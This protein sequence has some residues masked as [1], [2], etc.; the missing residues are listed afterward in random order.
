[1]SEPGAAMADEPL[2][3]IRDLRV[4]FATDEGP[5]T[6][7][8]GLSA[9]L[10]R[11]QVLAIVGESGSGKSASALAT[12]GLLPRNATAEGE[13]RLRGR[14]IL[15]LSEP[16]LRDLRGREI[17]MVFQD[18]MSSLNP[19]HTIGAQIEEAITLHRDVSGSEARARALELLAAVEI[20]EPAQRLRSY[21]H[22]F[23]GG[24]R[25]R[26][27]IAMAMANEPAVLI[28]DEPTTALDVT[29]QVQIFT[30]LRRLQREANSGVLLITHDLGVVAE[31]CDDVL[32][33]YAGRVVESGP[34][35]QVFAQPQHPYT[36]G[37]LASLPAR[38]EQG[39]LRAIPGQPPTGLVEH[40]G[41]PFAARCPYAMPV[42]RID[43]PPPLE[44]ALANPAHIAACHLSAGRRGEEL[45]AVKAGLRG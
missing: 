8:D 11:G 15:V 34:V 6:A 7:V 27:M 40:V 33:M 38:A 35:E 19:F 39:L 18:P 1:M 26:V 24:M 30:L 45:A 20:P 13:V 23:S 12:M 16:E 14:D 25:Q 44:P 21:P 10:A 31:T 3:E 29:T 43:P 17:S 36:W 37:L 5:L 28:A 41:C 32:V 22:E 9:T 4:R 2:L 42:C